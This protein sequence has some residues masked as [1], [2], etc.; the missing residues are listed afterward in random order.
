MRLRALQVR[1]GV[2]SANSDLPASERWYAVLVEA[3]VDKLPDKEKAV[4]L[5]WS[6][7][8]VVGSDNGRFPASNTTG[9]DFPKPEYSFSGTESFRLGECTK[10]WLMFAVNKSA[11]VGK[12]RYSNDSGEVAEWSVAE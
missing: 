10:G 8:T 9:G 11:Q 6:P 5:A 7:W 3:C 12:I 2:V 1:R 4:T